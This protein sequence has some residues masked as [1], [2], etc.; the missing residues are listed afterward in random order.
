MPKKEARRRKTGSPALMPGGRKSES[1]GKGLAVLP[2]SGLFHI[3]LQKESETERGRERESEI[4]RER[5]RQTEMTKEISLYIGYS[6]VSS[7]AR[8]PLVL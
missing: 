3:I 8:K 2:S 7:F 1:L 4:K 6:V 5:G